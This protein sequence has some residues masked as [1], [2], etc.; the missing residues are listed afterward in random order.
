MNSD[1]TTTTYQL[2]QIGFIEPMNS[3]SIE[4][5]IEKLSACLKKLF[6]AAVDQ[7]KSVLSIQVGINED[8]NLLL[9]AE[10]CSNDAPKSFKSSIVLGRYCPINQAASPTP[11]AEA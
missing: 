5:L 9:K 6:Q 11:P 7:D 10:G 4:E 2:E 1:F 3:H 8:G